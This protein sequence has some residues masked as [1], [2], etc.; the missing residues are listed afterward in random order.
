MIVKGLLYLPDGQQVGIPKRHSIKNVP[1]KMYRCFH[2]INVRVN[3]N[4]REE[5]IAI[6]LG[7]LKRIW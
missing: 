7:T 1:C 5:N 6:Y 3:Q 2:V 4:A